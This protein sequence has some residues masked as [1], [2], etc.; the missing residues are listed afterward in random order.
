LALLLLVLSE[1]SYS[2]DLEGFFVSMRPSIDSGST[3]YQNNSCTLNGWA[4]EGSLGWRFSSLLKIGLLGLYENLTIQ[5]PNSTLGPMNMVGYGLQ[6]RFFFISSI[7]LEG[8]GG[9]TQARMTTSSTGIDLVA[10]GTFY[11]IGPG[12]EFKVSDGLSLEFSLRV[13]NVI[14]PQNEF[15]DTRS[16]FY[17]SGLTLYLK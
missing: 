10:N 9:M 13:R 11:T 6:A 5:S 12:I 2:A 7:F 16:I 4:G 8:S 14:F 1:N 3:T 17:S 15:L